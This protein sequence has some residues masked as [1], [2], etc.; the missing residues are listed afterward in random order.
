MNEGRE[1]PNSTE[2]TS[3]ERIALWL[4]VQDLQWLSQQQGTKE[5]P[6]QEERERCVRIQRQAREALQAHRSL[7]TDGK[8]KCGNSGNFPKALIYGEI[9]DMLAEDLE[10][11]KYR[12]KGSHGKT[13]WF[14]SYCFVP[15]NDPTPRLTSFEI[16]HHDVNITFND[17]TKRWLNLISLKHLTSFL[18]S[19][20]YY[21]DR[22]SVFVNDL[23]KADIESILLELQNTGELLRATRSFEADE[24]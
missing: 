3:S 4:T 12:V 14:P 8:I 9:Y 16:D 15:L 11:R 2:D 18:Q 19:N 23:N 21:Q 10:N 17:G 20:L 7:V 24:D 22:A 1:R 13:R 5:T 6:S